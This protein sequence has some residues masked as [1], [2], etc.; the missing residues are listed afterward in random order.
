MYVD[1][2]PELEN[3]T[4][5]LCENL[6]KF[7]RVQVFDHHPKFG[8]S[9][10]EQIIGKEGFDYYFNPDK[11]AAIVMYQYLSAE[12]KQYLKFH[13]V[14][15]TIAGWEEAEEIAREIFK[16]VKAKLFASNSHLASIKEKNMELYYILGLILVKEEE[17]FVFDKN[18][19]KEKQ[20]N[21]F[22]K[23]KNKYLACADLIL[24]GNGGYNFADQKSLE[25]IDLIEEK[26]N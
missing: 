17:N 16:K 14:L 12:K 1:C 19:T 23:L 24:S 4:N 3:E 6:D 8:N 25:C 15:K 26:S 13:D 20:A 9:P 18:Y 7:D 11:C 22:R 10:V 5:F 2:T 21:N